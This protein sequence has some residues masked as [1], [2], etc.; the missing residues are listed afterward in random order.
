[1]AR[2]LRIIYPNAWYHVMN[3]GA[4]K[5]NIFLSDSDRLTFLELLHKIHERYHIEIHAYCLM[6]NHYHLL[7]RTPLPNLSQ[8]I[9]YLN[10]SYAQKFNFNKILDG[11][12]FRGRFK[13]VVVEETDY[14][15]YL[16]R[17]IHLNPVR[18][19]ICKKAWDY[20]WSSCKA[21]VGKTFNKPWLFTHE[22]L[23][24]LKPTSKFL[25][26]AI[27]LEDTED[28]IAKEML[29]KHFPIFGSDEFIKNRTKYHM[30]KKDSHPEIPDE[31]K[32]KIFQLPTFKKV[33]ES[34]NKETFGNYRYR[35]KINP[36]NIAIYLGISLCQRT[37]DQIAFE[38]SIKRSRVS[39]VYSEISLIIYKDR[40]LKYRIDKIIDNLWK[41]EM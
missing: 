21:Y 35:G 37:L 28:D 24:M 33:I 32:I 3:R 8:A 22:I 18:A 4:A 23:N 34:I 1:M 12:L 17:Y 7:V 26:Y 13:S 36:R 9:K 10:G 11:P 40:E 41:V 38:F 39:K 14:L 31:R 5:K 27:F 6:D 25:N 30:S 16:S 2:P 15:I 20:P 19:G 29:L